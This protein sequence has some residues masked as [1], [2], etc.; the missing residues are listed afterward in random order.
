MKAFMSDDFLLG[1]RTAEVL[2]HDHVAA[3]PIIDYHCHINPEDIALDRRFDNIAQL[4]LQNDHYKW[5]LMRL[6]GEDEANITGQKSS[7]YDK[8]TAFSRALPRAMGNPVYHWAHLELRRYFDCEL[9]LCP[10]TAEEIWRHCADRM[11]GGGFSAREIIRRSRVEA[12]ATTDDPADDLRWHRVIREDPA[13]N[14]KVVP[15]F[16]PDKALGITNP[17]FTGYIERLDE[18]VGNSINT[19]D[20]LYLALSDRINFFDELGCRSSDHGMDCVPFVKNPEALA[21]TAFS[22]ALRG[23]C[24]DQDAV[25][26]YKTALLIFLGK[27]Y[28]KRSW[29]MQLHYGVSRN[30]N[31]RMYNR[32]GP[33]T[34][35]DAI[36][37][38]NLSS[39]IPALLDALGVSLPKTVLYSLDPND[40]AFLDTVC[41]AFTERGVLGKVQHGSAWWFNDTLQGMKD[42]LTGLASRGL[43]GGFIGMLTDSRSLLSYA[44]HEYFRRVLCNLLGEWVE[45][46]EYSADIAALGRMAQD[47]SYYNVKNYFKL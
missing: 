35:F 9:T 13:F 46:G 8:F 18:S 10:D 38:R 17:D 47:I 25:A 19:L 7:D 45:N 27:S 20:D 32:I 11:I 2:Y 22:Q 41:G 34:G 6:N 30:L 31:T 3:M 23:D 43:L 5:R 39:N 4:W 14:V 28:A 42:H 12:I 21:S 15:T 40:N 37:G 16:R 33:D 36:S 1:N 26:A 24:I 29:V 44:R